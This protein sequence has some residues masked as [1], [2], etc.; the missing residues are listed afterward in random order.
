MR[1]DGGLGRGRWLLAALLAMLAGYVDAIGFLTLAGVFVSFMSGN[2]TRMAVAAVRGD[3][4]A[5]VPAAVIAAFVLGVVASALLAGRAGR[6]RKPAVLLLVTALLAAAAGVRMAI[7]GLPP[8][9]LLAAAMGAEN[10]VFQRD[11]E[12]SIGVTY[13]TGT[14]VKLGQRLA[15]SLNGGPRWGWVPMLL[16]WCGLVTGA[17]LGATAWPHAW[18]LWAAAG[19]A[20]LL[21][22]LAFVLVR[23]D[24][25][26]MRD[27]P[28]VSED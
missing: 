21:T 9:L 11:G 16:L 6:W 23:R 13:M 3:G 12:V 4:A 27:A 8:A 14:L 17:M 15:L 18:S 1:G 2:S 10:G 26:H 20:A 5:L 28:V 25:A 22:V 19:V 24:I 7:A